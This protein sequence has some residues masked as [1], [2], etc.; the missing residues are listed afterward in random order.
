MI[1]KFWKKLHTAFQRDCTSLLSYLTP[2]PLQ[3][4]LS[5][6]CL[7]LV[8]LS[9]VRWYLRVILFCIS[10]ICFF[11]CILKVTLLS[12]FQELPSTWDKVIKHIKPYEAFSFKS[13]HK[14]FYFTLR[15]TF[16]IMTH[17]THKKN[18]T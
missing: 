10:L 5:S 3:H 13:P 9:D 14:H 17:N 12:L 6:V 7:I 2:H 18:N 4:R 8:I 16:Y 1:P 11:K 15:N